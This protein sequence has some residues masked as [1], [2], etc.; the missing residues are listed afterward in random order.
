[1][2]KYRR[3]KLTKG[4]YATVDAKYYDILSQ[5][6]WC[7][8]SPGYAA[9]RIR[10]R[11]VLMHRFVAELEWGPSQKNVDHRNRR[12]CDNRVQ[13][14]RYADQSDN[15]MNRIK[16]RANTSGYKGVFWHKGAKKWMAQLM[17]RKRTHYLGLFSTPVEA[18]K[19]YNRKALEVAGEYANLNKV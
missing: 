1:M 13:N 14:L 18:A 5:H 2:A 11:L 17:Y 10:G 8:Q 15:N 9:T 16:S 19:A 7:Y 12:R 6:S 4:R 3:I